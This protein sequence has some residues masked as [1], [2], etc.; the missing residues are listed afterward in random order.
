MLTNKNPDQR[1]ISKMNNI[2]LGD[3]QDWRMVKK[4]H[5]KPL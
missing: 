1:N 2:I 4:R 3:A 5:I